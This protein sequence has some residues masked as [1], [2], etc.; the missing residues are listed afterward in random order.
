VWPDPRVVKFVTENFIPAR[1]H[2]KDDSALFQKFGEK[3]NAQWTPTI[4]ELDPAGIER[5]RIEGFLPNDEFL[6]QLMLGRAQI[7]FADQ[8][9]DEAERLFRENFA[10]TERLLGAEHANTAASKNFVGNVLAVKGDL[11]GAEKLQRESLTV[12]QRIFG[13][14]TA[15]SAF[16]VTSLAGTLEMQGRYEEAESL[17]GGA[18]DIVTSA[19]GVDNSRVA[20]VAVDLSRVR[21]ARGHAAG[22]AEMMRRAL[23]VR[24]RSYPAGH[25]RIAE[26]QALLGASLAAERR[27]DEAAALMVAADH[28]F[29]PI[30]G[31]Q[32]RDREANRQRLAQLRRLR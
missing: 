30:P 17:L 10:T 7:A 26:A 31:R 4:L 9:W 28:S 20:T 18:Y 12:R 3:Y 29:K 23:A 8:K 14:A 2:V 19:L 32:A 6:G 16:A 1:V 22:V 21:I 24:Q 13:P 25:W 15:E 11:A 5:Y 27:F